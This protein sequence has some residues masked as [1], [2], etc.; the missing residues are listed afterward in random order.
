M[1]KEINP[2]IFIGIAVVVVIGAVIMGFRMLQPA[3]YAPSP[4]ASG[5]G[6]G[7]PGAVNPSKQPASGGSTYYPMAPPNSIPGKPVGAG[8]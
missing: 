5:V 2:A 8:R 4:G 3:P 7:V 6:G 1:K